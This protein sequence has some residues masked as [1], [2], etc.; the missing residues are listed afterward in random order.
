MRLER[1]ASPGVK[2]T[3]KKLVGLNGPQALREVAKVHFRTAHEIAPEHYAAPPAREEWRRRT[4]PNV[5]K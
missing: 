5:T 4:S 1:G 3:A 2:E